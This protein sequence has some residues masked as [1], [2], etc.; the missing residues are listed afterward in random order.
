M[1]MVEYGAGGDDNIVYVYTCRPCVF[2]VS[3]KGKPSAEV[4]L[5]SILWVHI[6]F[7][8]LSVRTIL[9]C[10][11]IYLPYSPARIYVCVFCTTLFPV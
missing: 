6:F 2:F 5:R 11:K 4:M 3:K 8:I 10:A 7:F 9:Q 1:M